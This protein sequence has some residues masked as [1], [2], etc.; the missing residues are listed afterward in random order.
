MSIM[1]MRPLYSEVLEVMKSV[2]VDDEPDVVGHVGD[3]MRSCIQV[4][5][6]NFPNF[7]GVNFFPSA[8]YRKRN[9]LFFCDSKRE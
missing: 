7:F 6:Q 9:S 3:E 5:Q 4:L 1:G 2:T 8:L